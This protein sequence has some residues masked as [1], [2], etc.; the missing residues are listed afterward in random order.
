[1]GNAC[2]VHDF[3]FNVLGVKKLSTEKNYC[4]DWHSSTNPAWG[5]TGGD[6]VY[7]ETQRVRRNMY[8]MD[9]EV[10]QVESCSKMS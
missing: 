6:Y 7:V 10:F 9:T 5:F 3:F 1:M 2:I 8:K 4:W